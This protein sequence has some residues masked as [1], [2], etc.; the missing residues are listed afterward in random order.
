MVAEASRIPCRCLLVDSW[1]ELHQSVAEY[2]ALLPEAQK[3]P[4]DVYQERLGVCAQ[5]DKL[6]DGTC[7]L[8][9]CYVEARA[10][11]KGL[12]CPN[13]PPKWGKIE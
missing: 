8:C 13:V 3:A 1:P 10:A 6:R 4:E 5:C 9:G 2:V 11:K 7:G 12:R